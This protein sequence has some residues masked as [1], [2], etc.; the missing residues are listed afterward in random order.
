MDDTHRQMMNLRT[1]QTTLRVALESHPQ[2]AD[3]AC[4]RAL[5]LLAR[6]RQQT[7]SRVVLDAAAAVEAEVEGQIVT[8][9]QRG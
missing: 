6:V 2:R 1:I 8:S 4:T 3:A 9:R 7:T 5:M